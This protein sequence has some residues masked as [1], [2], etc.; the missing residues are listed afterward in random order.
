MKTRFS[1]IT[2]SVI[3]LG[4]G[5]IGAVSPVAQAAP[6][7]MQNQMQQARMERAAT[8]AEARI[9]KSQQEKNALA[10]AV[11]GK[12]NEQV[13]AI[14]LRNGMTNADLKGVTLRYAEQGS[15]GHGGERMAIKRVTIRGGCCP[16]WI[17]IT[18]YF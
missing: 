2:L 9:N 12:N 15:P 10:D 13:R 1:V 5:G 7:P 14:L 16:P 11:R 6:V 3:V 8:A 17:E 18:I 4:F